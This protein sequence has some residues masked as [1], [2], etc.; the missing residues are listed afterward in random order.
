MSD[1]QD[2]LAATARDV[3]RAAR[4]LERGRRGLGALA[5]PAA[6]EVELPSPLEPFRGVS[7]RRAYDAVVLAAPGHGPSA[8]PASL[9]R[10]VAHLTLARVGWDLEVDEAKAL[11]PPPGA[12]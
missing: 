12:P 5:T 3:E 10:W 1:A 7:G 11:R 4:A 9:A 6:S 8:L 2:P